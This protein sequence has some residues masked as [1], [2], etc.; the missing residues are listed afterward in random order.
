MKEGEYIC[1][2]V[3]DTG[4]GIESAVQEKVFEPFFT[5]KEVGKGTGLGL[6]TVYGIMQQNNGVITI[7]DS[8]ENGTV[9]ALYFPQKICELPAQEFKEHT[10]ISL[11]GT[12]RILLVEDEEML[13]QTVKKVLTRHGYEVIGVNSPN[14]ALKYIEECEQI[15]LLITDIIMPE[16]NG[17]QLAARI[18]SKQKNLTVLYMSGYTSS[19]ITDHG[20][21][22]EG[23]AFLQKPFRFNEL[24]HKIK[25]L[26]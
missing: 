1:L 11:N 14:E 7:I 2:T 12:A 26:L 5:T 15:D 13:L 6:S 22:E 3:S 20:V 16:L 23:V 25:E 19:V 17:R 10:H 4:S 24:L 18:L 21:L 9:M 8:S